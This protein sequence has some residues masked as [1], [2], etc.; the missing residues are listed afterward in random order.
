MRRTV[1]SLTKLEAW[2]MRISLDVVGVVD[3]DDGRAHEAVVGDV[4]VGAMEVFEEQ[5]GMAEFD[6]RLIRVEV[7]AEYLRPGGRL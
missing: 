3:E 6:P 4:A 5:D 7:A 1:R 2:L